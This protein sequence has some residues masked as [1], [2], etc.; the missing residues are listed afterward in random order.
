MHDSCDA[1]EDVSLIERIVARDAGAVAALYDRYG[2]L[3]YGLA[4]RILGDRG[5]AEDVTQEV[6]VQVW[7]GADTYDVTLGSPIAWLVR[8][9]RNRAIDRRRA[10]QVRVRAVESA[11]LDPPPAD[12]PET[13]TSQSELQRAVAQALGAL[14]RKQADLIEE[15][16]F[17]ELTQSELAERHTLPLGT[18][19]TR[20]R[21][22]M[23]A[24]R[25]Q[26]SPRLMEL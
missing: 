25:R 5:E 8:I 2:R 23:M 10:S 19:K 22:G 16:C 21:S 24:L 3:I 7:K 6:F 14:P 4:F 9:A 11:P 26:L 20:I 13:C 17:L 12:D 18:V 1:P 15:A